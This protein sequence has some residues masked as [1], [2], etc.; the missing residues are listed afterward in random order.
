MSEHPSRRHVL[1]CARDE[2]QLIAQHLLD[3]LTAGAAAFGLLACT[4]RCFWSLLAASQADMLGRRAAA[5]GCA[6]LANI[7]LEQLDIIEAVASLCVYESE[8]CHGPVG[9]LYFMKGGASLRPG[10]SLD[11][12]NHFA[13]ILQRHPRCSCRIDA[14]AVGSRAQRR[15]VAIARA[16]AV[17]NALVQHGAAPEALEAFSWGDQL[18]GVAGWA[19]GGYESRR[20]EVSFRLDGVTLPPRPAYYDGIEDCERVWPDGAVALSPSG[21]GPKLLDSSII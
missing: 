14:H 17:V 11:R 4:C 1:D 10:S 2:L 21:S 6:S 8:V 12:L 3:D 16:N 15:E 13:G 19:P 5:L 7:T 20:A 18:A 9:T